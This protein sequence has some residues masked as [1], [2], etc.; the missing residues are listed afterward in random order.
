MVPAGKA[1]HEFLVYDADKE[2]TRREALKLRFPNGNYHEAP[3]S[4]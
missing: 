3:S 1:L 2:K 4:D